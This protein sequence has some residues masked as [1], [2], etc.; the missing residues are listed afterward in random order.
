MHPGPGYTYSCLRSASN[1]EK[2]PGALGQHNQGS[3]ATAFP[4]SNAHFIAKNIDVGNTRR[5]GQVPGLWAN[6]DHLVHVGR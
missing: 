6:R 5:G 3:H 1:L 4:K 2:I